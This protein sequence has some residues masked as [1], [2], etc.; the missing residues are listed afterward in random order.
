MRFSS[1]TTAVVLSLAFAAS[2]VAALRQPYEYLAALQKFQDEFVNPTSVI[3]KGRSESLADD[4]V[5]RVD[6]TTTFEGQELNTEYL[7]GLFSGVRNENSTSIIGYPASQTIQALVVEPPI[8]Y[9]SAIVQ[10]A[11]PTLNLSV[12]VQLDVTTA[13]NDDLKIISYDAAF[14]RWSQQFKYAS[15]HIAPQI[16]KELNET[17]DPVSTNKTAL[18][19]RK[20][21]IELCS[22][23]MDHCT[24]DNQQYDSYEQCYIFLTEERPFGEATEGGLDTTW[25]RYI[26][27]NMV[28][29]R[30]NVHCS[31]IGPSGGDM[32]IERDYLDIVNAFPFSQT[33]VAPNA[34]WDDR[35]MAALSEKSAEELGKAK[36]TLV[37]PSTIPFYSIPTMAFF[38]VLYVSAKI[39]EHLFRRYS[40]EYKLLSPANQR[41][42]VTYL[43]NTIFTTVAL[44]FQLIATPS[45][46]HHYTLL[47]I[48]TI[49]VTACIISALYLFEMVY[50][51]SMR[52][53]LLAHHFCT[54]LAIMSLYASIEKTYHPATV[55]IGCIWLFQ[56][57]TE[58][59][60]FIG[61][62]MY[63]LKCGPKTVCNVLRFAAVQSFL[64]KFA[65]A[66]Y[67]LVEHSLKLVQFT[68]VASDVYF[69]VIVYSVGLLLLLT[70][71]YG[72]WAV[73][74]IS[75]KI[76]QQLKAGHDGSFSA[77]PSPADRSRGFVAPH[78]TPS[79]S[80]GSLAVL[81]V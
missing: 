28:P 49:T 15:D 7:F 10:L 81:R 77:P 39:V 54:L 36:L 32:C 79:N 21:A 74:A 38:A 63:R 2:Q 16:A 30:P 24:G 26:H 61:L 6:V 34:T 58:Q 62:L 80:K 43:L 57:T 76:S 35:D 70:Q 66:V 29:Y 5:G 14:R 67:L 73:W 71:A 53:S 22:T 60:I 27:R 20:A 9:F 17:Y 72:S 56:A 50:R 47:G 12:P 33:L 69:S 8:V 46:A 45:L 4:C 13:W 48:Q 18:F 64:V 23:A 44:V 52:P 19:A 59:S 37:F 55:T 1:T 68:E 11:Y 3:E 75:L 65:F 25:C 51:D 42:T 41:N 40:L 31:H 78:N